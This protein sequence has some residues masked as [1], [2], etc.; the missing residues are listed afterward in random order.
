MGTNGNTVV[1]PA[2]NSYEWVD[3]NSG[4]INTNNV[5]S[6][7]REVAIN[8]GNGT[9]RAIVTNSQG[10]LIMTQAITM[11]YSVV[12]DNGTPP[13]PSQCKNANENSGGNRTVDSEGKVGGF[14][15]ASEYMQYTFTGQTAGNTTITVRYASGD[16]QAGIML[17]VNGTNVPLFRPGTASWSPNADATTTINLVQNTNTI[18][19]QGSET[20]NFTFNRI[21][22]GSSSTPPPG[23]FSVA[24]TVSNANADCNAPLTLNANCSGSDCNGVSYSWSGN[25][26]TYSGVS[27]GITGPGSNG[28]FTY[29]LTATKAGCTQQSGSVSVNVSGCGGTPPGLSI[30][31]AN[32]NCSTGAV[33]MSVNGNNGNPLEYRAIGLQDWSSSLLTVPAHQ[34]NGTSFTF[35]ARQAG[36]NEASIGY[37]TSCPGYR[38][39]TESRQETT[40]GLWVS[41]N[42]T[43]GKVVARF[44]LTAGERGSLSVV[45]LTG[46][47]LQSRSVVG[48]G[49]SQEETL[50]LSQQAAGVYVVR[51]QT[52]AGAK[53]AKVVLQQ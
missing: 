46:Q 53:T 1:A 24:P 2:G 7:Q 44:T 50:D 12:D 41:P 42:P 43:S 52:A 16:S 18:R 10:N 29:T 31:S 13:P 4:T 25:G 38:I 45:N 32:L 22:L 6:T 40:D 11:P 19:I 14:G 26:Q 3:E 15:N 47:S 48:T 20:G 23:C 34:R 35:W 8:D 39:A 36:N 30:A 28:T 17:V 27:P 51:L 33:T 9:C 5:M 21:C 37:T 49:T